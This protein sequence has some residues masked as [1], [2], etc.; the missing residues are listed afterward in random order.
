MAQGVTGPRTCDLLTL[1]PRAYQ[2][3]KMKVALLSRSTQPPATSLRKPQNSHF[4]HSI[5]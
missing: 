1:E 5:C 3:L 2:P 4:K